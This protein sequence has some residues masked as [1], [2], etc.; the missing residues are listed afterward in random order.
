[1]QPEWRRRTY[2]GREVFA[3]SKIVL[4]LVPG[5]TLHWMEMK[6]LFEGMS[7]F[8]EKKS[9][10]TSPCNIFALNVTSQPWLSVPRS[11]YEKCVMAHA[12]S[13][14]NNKMSLNDFAQQISIYVIKIHLI[15]CYSDLV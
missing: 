9:S 13:F 11:V 2:C 10:I 6:L 15:T 5:P 1:V 4:L 8:R 12:F 14:N 3:L 7:S